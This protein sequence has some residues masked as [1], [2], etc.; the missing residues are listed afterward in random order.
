MLQL[1]VLIEVANLESLSKILA[2]KVRSAGLQSLAVAH[3]GFDGIGDVGAGEFLGVGFLPGDYGNS[4]I[5]HRKIGVDVQHL[6][7]FRFGFL[8]RGV[9]GVT[10]LP[11][12][13]QR[14]QEKLGAQL[15]AHDAVPLIHEHRKIAVGLNPFGPHV[16]D[17]GL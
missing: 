17:D 5:V 13:F 6:A 16:A 12:K 2:E 3:H 7:G 15:P 11:E 14:A 4:G 8:A 9:R 10:L 1:A